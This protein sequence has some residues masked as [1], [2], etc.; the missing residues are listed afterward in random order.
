VRGLFGE[1]KVRP[2][3]VSEEDVQ[4]LRKALENHSSG[5]FFFA[6]P[7]TE[8]RTRDNRIRWGY[9]ITIFQGETWAELTDMI[10]ESS[11]KFKT[12]EELVEYLR[13][14]NHAYLLEHAQDVE[15]QKKADAETKS[16][17]TRFLQGKKE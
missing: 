13:E 12:L 1:G 4:E 14:A 5:N 11:L 9:A 10:S 8:F 16:M 2:I 15:K 17:L 6:L 7:H 3:K